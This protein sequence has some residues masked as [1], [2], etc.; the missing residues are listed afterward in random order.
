MPNSIRNILQSLVYKG[1][2][3]QEQM[4]KI[5]RNINPVRRGK[6]KC[7]SYDDDLYF[8]SS[9]GEEIKLG[10]GEMKK[11]DGKYVVVPHFPRYCEN[12]GARMYKCNE[13]DTKR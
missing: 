11:I 8:C 2:L 10:Y 4:D 3:S 13:T 12:C 6:W 7:K 5:M 9:C 1:H